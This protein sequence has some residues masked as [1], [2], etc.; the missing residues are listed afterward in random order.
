MSQ[1]AIKRL[2]QSR[3]RLRKQ[4]SELKSV[5]SAL[6]RQN[7]ILKEQ[8]AVL[9][10]LGAANQQL[11]QRQTAKHTG[12]GV[13]TQ[14]PP[15]L[16]AFALTLNF[17]SPRAYNYVMQAFDTCLPHPRT[18]RKWYERVD[19]QPGFSAEAFNALKMK[20]AA[21]MAQGHP[22]I[23]SLMV[24]EMS[25]RQHVQW[26][27]GN[28]EGFVDIGTGVDS[29]CLPQAKAAFV[30]MAV[31]INGRWKLPLGYFFVD[32]IVGEQRANLVTQSMLRAHDA[33]A[34]IVSL[35]CDGAPANIAMLQELGC[36]FSDV[37]RLR[38]TFPHPATKEPVA[39][40]LDP[41][42]MLKLVRNAFA[43]KGAY[44][45]GDEKIVAWS[46]VEQLHKLQEKEGLHFANCAPHMWN[47]RGSQ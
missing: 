47:G 31:A 5:I 25:I 14:Y 35:T 6:T 1:K 46:Y 28:F 8:A 39:A 3:R 42:H 37:T 2:Q 33:G 21:S 30:V 18:L 12:Q 44:L 32:G 22:T 4:N 26:N 27:R 34:M 38:T 15:E 19:G 45:D 40:F 23:C 24:D 9:E 13:P 10:S 43:T 36:S 7:I 20:C 17:Y 16:R 29:D 11:L 41:C